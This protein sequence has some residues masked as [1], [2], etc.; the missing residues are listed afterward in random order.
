LLQPTHRWH[1]YTESDDLALMHGRENLEFVR[2]GWIDND[3]GDFKIPDD[4]I[5]AVASS[6]GAPSAPPPSN[7]ASGGT[8]AGIPR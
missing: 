6:G 4:V 3:T 7:P 5:N 1:E 2:R 8:G